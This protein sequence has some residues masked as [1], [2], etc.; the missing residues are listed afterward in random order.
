[1]KMKYLFVAL[2]FVA[3]I[4][5]KAQTTLKA[6]DYFPGFTLKSTKGTPYTINSQSKAKGYIL[7][8]M[9][10][11]CDHCIMYEPRVMA[12]DAKYKVK[13]YPVVAIG[14]YGDDEVKYPLDAMKEMTKLAQTKKFTFPYVSDEQFKYTWLFGIKATPRA[15]VLQKQGAGFVV[16]YIGRIDDE[17]NPKKTPQ[18][19]FVEE[20]IN[21][22]I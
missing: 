22:L 14:P 20:V 15:V 3:S 8:F 18:N 4:N 19:K 16:K 17:E 5:L 7:V 10:P 1:M 11:T 12:L 9:T 6:G 2:L 13:G 21:R